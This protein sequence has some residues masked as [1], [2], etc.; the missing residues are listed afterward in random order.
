MSDSN[1]TILVVDDD[2]R[3]IELTTSIL[4]DEGYEVQ[5]ADSSKLALIS[6]AAQSPELI[7]LDVGTPGMDGFEVCR[8]LKETEYC[9]QIPI[10][11]VSASKETP[12]LGEGSG[13]GRG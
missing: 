2:S 1:G 3:A 10:V 9:R 7:L 11:F 6:V 5:V 8:R 4:K 13:G 12:S